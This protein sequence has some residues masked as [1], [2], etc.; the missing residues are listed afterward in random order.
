MLLFSA[1]HVPAEPQ[2]CHPSGSHRGNE[3]SC[4]GFTGALQNSC[5]VTEGGKMGS[6]LAFFWVDTRTLMGGC[7]R[8]WRICPAVQ[9]GDPA[10]AREGGDA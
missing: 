10:K 6:S 9:G 1:L 7:G 5:V 8:S 2:L 3:S 4:A